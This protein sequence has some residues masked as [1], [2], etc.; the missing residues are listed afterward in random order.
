MLIKRVGGLE[1]ADE[2]LANPLANKATHINLENKKFL[3]ELSFFKNKPWREIVDIDDQIEIERPDLSS[4]VNISE[5]CAEVA[6]LKTKK[7]QDECVIWE[8]QAKV[9]VSSIAGKGKAFYFC[10]NINDAMRVPVSE[11]LDIILQM[12]CGEDMKL[13]ME[14]R[15]LN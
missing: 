8:K 7:N 10:V 9:Y 2:V 5:L 4:L 12:K 15:T 6:E 1:A 14:I 11:A 3:L 13:N